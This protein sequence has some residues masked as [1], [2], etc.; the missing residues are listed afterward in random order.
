M[1][2]P[3]RTASPT[4]AAPPH[5]VTASASPRTSRA[6]SRSVAPSARLTP[7]SRIRSKTA[8]A[9][10]F[11]T[12]RPPMTRP[13]AAIPVSSAE[14]NTVDARSCRDSSLGIWTFTP[15]T[16]SRSEE[17][18]SELQSPC[19]LVCRLLLEKKKTYHLI[20][21]IKTKHNTYTPPHL[22]VYHL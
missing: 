11:A 9:I 22:N 5:T 8:A 16:R 17:H 20:L 18:T 13:R 21:K 12:D 3:S 4:P 19:N 6:R 10:V 1:E 14:K 7:K 2:L 15:A